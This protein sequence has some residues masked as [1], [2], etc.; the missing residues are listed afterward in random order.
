MYP[1][2]RSGNITV[3]RVKKENIL[4]LWSGVL[5][6]LCQQISCCLGF[7]VYL[8]QNSFLELLI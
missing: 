6:P 4:N 3:I 7:A 1:W 5:P 2:H 8:P